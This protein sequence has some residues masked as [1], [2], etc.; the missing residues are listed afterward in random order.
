MRVRVRVRVQDGVLRL[1][2]AGRSLLS[3]PVPRAVPVAG[4]RV[5]SHMEVRLLG[6]QQFVV[7]LSFDGD[8]GGNKVDLRHPDSTVRDE[9]LAALLHN[10][11][12]REDL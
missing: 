7:H 1:T 12:V 6:K 9:L 8:A 10:G 4:S 11:A 3:S 5:R 2:D